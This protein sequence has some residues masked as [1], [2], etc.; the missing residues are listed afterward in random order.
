MHQHIKIAYQHQLN[1]Y[2]LQDN[3]NDIYVDIFHFSFILFTS[4]QNWKTGKSTTGIDKDEYDKK[5]YI[6]LLTRLPKPLLK[7]LVE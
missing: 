7:Q 6:V 2:H 3:R 5:D 4:G 1:R